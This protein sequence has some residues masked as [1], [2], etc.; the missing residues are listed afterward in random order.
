MAESSKQ[1]LWVVNYSFIIDRKFS[2][3]RK[4]T[5]ISFTEGYYC[6]NNGKDQADVIVNSGSKCPS[7][8]SPNILIVISEYQKS[9]E[10]EQ[11][12]DRYY[13]FPGSELLSPS[14]ESG[15]EAMYS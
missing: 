3:S 12:I 4:L 9:T 5:R 13:G 2:R 10:T 14:N 7:D 11:N 15:G 1:Y 6:V 8:C